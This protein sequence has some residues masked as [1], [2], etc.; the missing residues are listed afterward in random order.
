MPAALDSTAGKG[1]GA[2]D[3]AEPIDFGYIGETVVCATART[4]LQVPMGE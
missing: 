1:V 2:I 4:D 3:S